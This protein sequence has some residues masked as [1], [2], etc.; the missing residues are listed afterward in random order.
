M[1]L[2]K[3]KVIKTGKRTKQLFLNDKEIKNV[4]GYEIKTNVEGN[5][6]VIIK[7]YVKDV[8]IINKE[9]TE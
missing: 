8:T 6:E 3:F 2:Q 4:F 7:M 9:E 1:D 5:D